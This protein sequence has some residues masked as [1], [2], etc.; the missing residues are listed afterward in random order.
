MGEAANRILRTA[1]AFHRPTIAAVSIDGRWSSSASSM[2]G[3]RV[4]AP[5]K[6]SSEQRPRRA[7]FG[8]LVVSFTRCL[9]GVLEVGHSAA[10]GTQPA[11]GPARFEP[12]C[13][14]VVQLS[15]LKSQ[16]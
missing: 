7:L 11:S 5:D 2:G 1:R 12:A 3:R 9:D 13:Q 16:L 14:T 10:T 4:S 8:G 6:R 15:L